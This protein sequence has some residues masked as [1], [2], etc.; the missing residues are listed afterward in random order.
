MRY[1]YGFIGCGNMGGAL[2]R[3]VAKAVPPSEIALSSISGEA[4]SLAAALGATDIT[5]AEIAT[6]CK[7]IFL[8]VKP[9]NMADMLSGISQVMASRRDRFVIVSMAAG[10]SV[11]TVCAL[12]G[13]QYPMIRIMPNTPA[14]IG[15]G[16]ILYAANDKV[17]PEELDEFKKIMSSAGKIDPLPE[18]LID[19]ASA[20]SGCGPAFAFMFIEA[21]ADGGVECG[22]PRDK[23]QLYA[24]QTLLGSASLLIES[25]AHPGSLKDAVCSPGGSTIEGVHALEKGAFRASVMSAVTEAYKKSR[26]LGNLK[27]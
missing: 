22:I 21:M 2:A 24:A 7:Y 11:A 13:G 19:A 12:A 4:R 14:S 18:G 15:K 8:A 1:K 9:Q 26:E 5:N 27:K 6:E 23:A 3:A 10:I 20:V 16:M 17:L 25:G